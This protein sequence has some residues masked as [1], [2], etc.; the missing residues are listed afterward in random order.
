[1]PPSAAI[2]S[3]LRILSSTSSDTALSRRCIAVGC[4]SGIST[5]ERSKRAPIGVRVRSSTHS[6]LPRFSP[7][8]RFAVSSRLRRVDQSSSMYRWPSS[9]SKVLMCER[10]HFCVSAM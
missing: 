1:M 8:R 9:S 2:S 5:Q 10:S 6:R 4:S 7:V 3:C